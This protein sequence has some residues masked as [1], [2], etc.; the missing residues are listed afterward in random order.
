[1]YVATLFNCTSGNV[2]SPSTGSYC[3][4]QNSFVNNC[5]TINC[6]NTTR[7]RYIQ[8]KYGFNQQYYALCLPGADPASP[9]VFVCPA[10]TLPNITAFPATCNYRCWRVGFFQNTLDSTKYFE[11]YLNNNLRFESVER[12]CPSGSYFDTIRSE[13]AVSLRSTSSLISNDDKK[14]L[15]V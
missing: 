4:R 6:G 9:L 8:I 14:I 15:T 5:Q 2:F 1:M 10:N 11:C 12:S 13:C 7:L 3:T